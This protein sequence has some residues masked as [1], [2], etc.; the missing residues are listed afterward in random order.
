MVF[1][2]KEVKK[3]KLNG[4][5]MKQAKL[6]PNTKNTDENKMVRN[7]ENPCFSSNAGAINL[8]N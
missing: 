8:Q 3:D 1:D 4:I 5:I 2:G 6:M 7:T